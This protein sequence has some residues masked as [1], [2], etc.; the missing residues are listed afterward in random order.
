MSRIIAWHIEGINFMGYM[1]YL[2]RAIEA[3]DVHPHEKVMA[4]QS[5]TNENKSMN[6]I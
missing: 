5:C 3:G 4:V 1:A 6:Y 2:C